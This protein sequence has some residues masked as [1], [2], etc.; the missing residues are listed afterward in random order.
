MNVN[1]NT[2]R[3]IFAVMQIRRS[4]VF[5]STPFSNVTAILRDIAT[6]IRFVF[7][8]YYERVYFDVGHQK[9]SKN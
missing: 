2:P 3:Q 1:I 6:N 7:K 5:Q 4:L 9:G 8:R